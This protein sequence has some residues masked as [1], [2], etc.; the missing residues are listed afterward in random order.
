MG[1]WRSELF[2]SANP[3]RPE[4]FES[5][6]RWRNEA[7]KFKW[8]LIELVQ[9]R[10][11]SCR[12]IYKN[13]YMP[14]EQ[15]AEFLFA[16]KAARRAALLEQIFGPTMQQPVPRPAQ[17]PLG[18]IEGAKLSM[19]IPA[20]SAGRWL[21]YVLGGRL[22]P[23]TANYWKARDIELENAYA[24]M[25]IWGWERGAI[26]TATG[27]WSGLWVKSMA[28]WAMEALSGPGPSESPF[29]P[30]E[31]PSCADWWAEDEVMGSWKDWSPGHWENI[32]GSPH[33]DPLLSP[34][35]PPPSPPSGPMP[36]IPP[37][38]LE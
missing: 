32:P 10:G 7:D 21:T 20:A 17:N 4:E 33:Y 6:E 29:G 24:R 31:S 13:V 9:K 28:S 37:W 14:W 19:W 5:Y 15:R 23:G 36:E 35:P 34:P 18:W 38:W 2:Y 3:P 27:I 12:D 26:E 11:C 25:N 1:R 8:R 22:I 16:Q 30:S